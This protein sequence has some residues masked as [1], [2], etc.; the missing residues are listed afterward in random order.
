MKKTVFMLGLLLTIAACA[1]DPIPAHI[2]AKVDKIPAEELPHH[3]FV[4][5]DS[6]AGAQK[7]GKTACRE[8]VR[9][10]YLAQEMAREERN[11]FDTDSVE[12]K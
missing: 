11:T 4:E 8:R 6:C 5:R 2:Q 3:F 7:E 10:E 9:R 12:V 1:S